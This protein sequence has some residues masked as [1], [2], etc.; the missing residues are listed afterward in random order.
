MKAKSWT[1]II[2]VS[3]SVL[4]HCAENIK[5]KE[6]LVFRVSAENAVGVGPPAQ[7]EV[8]RLQKHASEW[9]L[10]DFYYFGVVAYGT[11]VI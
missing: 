7:S 3:G 9:K 6:E 4:E 5:E 11:P 8:L 10:P 2:T 1:K